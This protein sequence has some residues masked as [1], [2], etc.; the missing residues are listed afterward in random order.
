MILVYL[1]SYL[2]KNR[3]AILVF[4]YIAYWERQTERDKEID[5]EKKCR[6]AKWLT[7]LLCLS[8]E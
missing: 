7:F 3:N 6:N 2:F 1:S 8:P 5:N 4:E